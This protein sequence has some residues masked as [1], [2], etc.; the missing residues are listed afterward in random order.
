MT[1][2]TVKAQIVDGP[3]QGAEVLIRWEDDR[4][5][6]GC[7][8]DVHLD[9]IGQHPARWVPIQIVDAYLNPPD[10]GDAA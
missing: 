7:T 4:L 3:M 10:L 5:M 6:V 8:V 9:A 2:E 1:I